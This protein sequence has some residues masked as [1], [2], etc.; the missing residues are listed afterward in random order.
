MTHQNEEGTYKLD[1]LTL[2][3]ILYQIYRLREWL[4]YL[5]K[6]EHL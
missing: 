4:L 3:D 1:E 5:A 2:N 6:D